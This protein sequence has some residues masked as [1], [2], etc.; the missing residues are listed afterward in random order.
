MIATAA[1]GAVA[2]GLVRDQETGL[3]VAPGDP[4]ELAAAIDRLLGDPVLRA[5][6]GAAGKIAVTGYTYE[7]MVAAFDLA[8]AAAAR[9]H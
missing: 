5:S 9:P 2:G 7:A 1:V 8:L 6:L 4:V 3:V